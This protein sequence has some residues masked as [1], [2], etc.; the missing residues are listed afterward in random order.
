M[1]VRRHRVA[2][3]LFGC[4]QNAG[5]SVHKRLVHIVGHQRAAEIAFFAVV[6]NRL[7]HHCDPGRART[8]F[9]CAS[10]NSDVKERPCQAGDACSRMVAL[11]DACTLLPQ[12]LC[13][14][15]WISQYK[16]LCYSCKTAPTQNGHMFGKICKACYHQQ[17]ENVEAVNCCFC[18]SHSSDVQRKSCTYAPGVCERRVDTCSQCTALRSAVVCQRCWERDWCASCFGCGEKWL[19]NIADFG[20]LCHKCFR[21][22][23]PARERCTLLQELE[24][25]L[26][27]MKTQHLQITGK[28]PALQ[29]LTLPIVRPMPSY[30][31]C[32]DFLSP[33]HCRLCLWD[34]GTQQGSGT[35]LVRGISDP[36]LLSA[37][38]NDDCLQEHNTSMPDSTTNDLEELLAD[39]FSTELDTTLESGIS[40]SSEKCP[41]DQ[42]AE[43][44]KLVAPVDPSFSVIPAVDTHIQSHHGWTAAEYRHEVLGRALAEW[45]TPITAQVVRTRFFAYKESLRD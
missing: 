33:T 44:E 6:Q 31:K 16:G 18:N 25:H 4:V 32:A 24:Q 42:A 45:L 28:E 11:C 5:V 38:V 19:Q 14:M 37:S 23:A 20:R 15:C 39:D 22:H 36:H 35:T 2:G 1:T 29:L 9:S 17:H 13:M 43:R 26:T 41:V 3:V 7:C 21:L 40:N 27:R 8:C 34:G 30:S 10:K 12:V